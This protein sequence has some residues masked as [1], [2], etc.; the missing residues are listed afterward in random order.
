MKITS[1]F[2]VLC[3]R[4]HFSTLRLRS[5]RRTSQFGTLVIL[6]LLACAKRLTQS[7]LLLAV[8]YWLVFH[9]ARTIHYVVDTPTCSASSNSNLD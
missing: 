2:F 9:R 1:T 8:S 7:M 6:P 4:S 5:V 3:F